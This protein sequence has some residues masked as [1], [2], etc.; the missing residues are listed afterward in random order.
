MTVLQWSIVDYVK[1]W[2]W[3]PKFI[4]RDYIDHFTGMKILHMYFNY[5]TDKG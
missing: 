5:H 4:A 2:P 1:E 3:R